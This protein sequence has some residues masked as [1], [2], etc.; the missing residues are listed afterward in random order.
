MKKFFKPKTIV[1]IGASRDKT[2][3]GYAIMKN[4]KNFK[5]N[6][7]LV[8][9]KTKEIAKKK[10]YP[11]VKSIKKKIDLAIIAVPA[12]IVKQV[13]KE[14][15]MERI[16]YVIIVSAGFSEVGN[17]KLEKELLGISRRYNIHMLGP[18]CLGIITPEINASFASVKP[19]KGNVAFISQS[20]ALIVG[21]LDWAVEEKYGFSA[22]VSVGNVLDLQT[23]SFIDYLSH[24]RHT[25]VIAVYLE[26]LKDGREFMN[27]IQTCK[28]PVIVLKPGKNVEALKA[29][30]S[31]TG[32]LAG[33]HE[34]Y[35]A[36]FK[37]AGAIVVNSLEELFAVAKTLSFQPKAEENSFAIVTNAGGPGVL[38]ADYCSDYGINLVDLKHSTLK[39]LD[40][41]MH[42]AYS[43]SNPL[44]IVGDAGIERWKH[45][46]KTLIREK[47]ISGLLVVLTPQAM[48]PTLELAKL[49]VDL[50]R[51]EKPIV[52][53]FIGGKDTKRAVNLLELNKI[54]N[55]V[56]PRL[57][58]LGLSKLFK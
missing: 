14:C 5:D 46:L 19:R 47:Y 3:V 18:N 28:K 20:G 44:D 50:K 16:K 49:L 12:K 37:Q 55:F 24:D 8:N 9:P 7:F 10:V 39:K 57:A 11:H 17:E 22:L 30:K 4:L 13:L 6:L 45:A 43:R 31:H 48:T 2:S 15:G 36:A 56:E 35:T 40:R 29:I 34:I 54:P 33:E 25:K 41:Y 51:Y 32:A 23:A 52:C 42:S 1:L 21:V 26:S 53:C 27:S 58:A 38:A